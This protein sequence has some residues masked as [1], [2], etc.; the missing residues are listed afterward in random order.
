MQQLEADGRAVRVNDLWVAVERRDQIRAV[1]PVGAGPCPALSRED[2]IREL[3]RGRIEILGPT[4]AR[5][6]G[7]SLGVSANEADAAL[8]ALESEG[9][10]L[11][12]RFTQTD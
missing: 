1:H 5:A 12:G 11:R 10:V 6:L 8:L 7:E 2:A 9:V 3:L 4:T